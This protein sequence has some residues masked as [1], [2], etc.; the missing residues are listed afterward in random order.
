MPSVGATP[1]FAPDPFT[2]GDLNDIGAPA[3]IPTTAETPSDSQ[4]TDDVYP[5]DLPDPPDWCNPPDFV[6]PDLPT[7]TG[8]DDWGE[9]DNDGVG[10]GGGQGIASTTMWLKPVEQTPVVITTVTP[11]IIDIQ[12][13][14]EPSATKQEYQSSA[15][16]APTPEPA[17]DKYTE[18][19]GQPGQSTAGQN[20]P[21]TGGSG[22][23]KTSQGRPAQPT[24]GQPA[25]GEPSTDRRPNTVVSHVP[26]SQQ[27]ASTGN[28]LLDAIIDRL[29]EA[30]PG[31]Q[32]TQGALPTAAVSGEHNIQEPQLAS[33][34]DTAEFKQ[35][36]SAQSLAPVSEP[37]IPGAANT[38]P[39][40]GTITPG[41]ANTAPIPG[42]I[43]PGVA[44]TV[45]PQDD[46]AVS[47]TITLGSATLSLTPGLSTI[48]GT[49]TD[50]TL[51]AIQ[52]DS[53]S[54]TVITVSS[55]GTAITATI[56]KAPATVTLP[57]TGW[58]A[59][60]TGDGGRGVHTT[61][62]GVTAVTTSSKGAAD[63][64]RA[65]MI[66]LTSFLLG[67]LGLASTL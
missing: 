65:N 31:A 37:I 38:A 39:I 14:I 63:A 42:T 15:P 52:T 22:E 34:T 10:G 50:T 40:P 12:T 53:V 46:I 36:D 30:Q 49:G 4:P 43:T 51:I 55:S 26:A 24:P 67:I 61:R 32:P 1:T 27:T 47:N 20:A 19:Q 29:G 8:W 33:P 48:V 28:A 60:I 21:Q 44:N 18:K 9:W 13:N 35:D 17:G 6:Q 57:K 7:R 2:S 45:S 58:D 66:E 25:P 41:A 5:C 11:T 64:K 16:Q 3:P 59:S 62:A 54:H 23:V 56:T